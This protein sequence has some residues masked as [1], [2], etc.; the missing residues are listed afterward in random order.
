MNI[1]KHLSKLVAAI[2][3]NCY[4]PPKPPEKIKIAQQLCEVYP[5]PGWGDVFEIGGQHFRIF[6]GTDRI[7]MFQVELTTIENEDY[8]WDMEEY[9]EDKKYQEEQEKKLLEY[10]KAK[11]ESL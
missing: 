10:L 6:N 2:A 5:V 11:H 3:R 1:K 7:Y 8:V 4:E 9:T